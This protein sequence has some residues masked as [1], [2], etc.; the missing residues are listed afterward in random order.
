MPN[1]TAAGFTPFTVD[2]ELAHEA[3]SRISPAF[4]T[5]TVTSVLTS[6][7]IDRSLRPLFPA[8]YNCETQV[9]CD[10]IAFDTLNGPQA[11]SINAAS[12]AL[13]VSDVPWNGPVG[14]VR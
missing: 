7:L 1:S 13:A 9:V 4:L 10:V 6:R 12:L 11:P 2:Y 5:K 3:A 14:A 8:D